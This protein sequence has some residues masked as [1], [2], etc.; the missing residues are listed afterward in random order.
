MSRIIV[1]NSDAL[2]SNPLG[3]LYGIFVILNSLFDLD[4][5]IDR[6]ATYT[7]NNVVLQGLSGLADLVK[8]I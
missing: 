5:I 4:G 7:N 1:S 2:N 6:L 8:T 3:K